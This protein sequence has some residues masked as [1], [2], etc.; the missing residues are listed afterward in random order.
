MIAGRRQGGDISL[1]RKVERSASRRMRPLPVSRVIVDELNDLM[2]VAGRGWRRRSAASPDG[3]CRGYPYCD[4][5]SALGGCH[6]GV[7]KP[8]FPH[9]AFSVASQP[10]RGRDRR[11]R[12]R[13]AGGM[14][15]WVSTD[16]DRARP[17]IKGRVSEEEI[18]AGRVG[19]AQK[20]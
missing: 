5:T 10:T 9:A 18:H 6:T 13:E 2:I 11:R 17:A 19:G 12:S 4:A 15:T 3:P 16:T 14:A 20:D 1:S 8:T 7:I